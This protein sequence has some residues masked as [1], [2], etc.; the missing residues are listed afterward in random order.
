MAEMEITGFTGPD[1][2][3]VAHGDIPK[4]GIVEHEFDGYIAGPPHDLKF[5]SISDVLPML[6]IP[7]VEQG[8]F[9][10]YICEI[11]GE[12]ELPQEIPIRIENI[13][14]DPLRYFE[15]QEIIKKFL[16]NPRP[17]P[18]EKHSEVMGHLYDAWNQLWLAPDS[19]DSANIKDWRGRVTE[20]L[21]ERNIVGELKTN[22]MMAAASM[23]I[24][25]KD[26]TKVS[27][28]SISWE[29]RSKKIPTALEAIL[30]V[31][32]LYRRA[33]IDK[34]PKRYEVVKELE[35]RCALRP[36]NLQRAFNFIRQ[37][38]T[39]EGYPLI[40]PKQKIDIPHQ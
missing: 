12:K 18:Y 9:Q 8:N 20:Y 15:I 6:K 28:R 32:L 38:D 16:N 10:F 4:T 2:N 24:K 26:F 29:K 14:P 39:L 7:L 11:D 33:A 19:L 30:E 31:S 23:F 35:Q 36:T 34:K 37:E 5:V 17:F 13:V 25:P 21:R 27:N 40:P 1:R 3:S 22:A